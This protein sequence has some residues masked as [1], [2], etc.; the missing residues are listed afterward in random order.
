MLTTQGA[1]RGGWYSHSSTEVRCGSRRRL[2]TEKAEHTA[3]G[4]FLSVSVEFERSHLET[5]CLR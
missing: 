3:R 4:R 5:A 2:E 1:G